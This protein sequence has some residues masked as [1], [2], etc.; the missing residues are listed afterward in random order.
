MFRENGYIV[1]N[2]DENKC[3]LIDPGS[4]LKPFEEKL[5][6]LNI[7][8]NSILLTHAHLDHISTA[9]CLQKKY[10]LSV[11][12]HRNDLELA[13]EL[14]EY[15][16]WFGMPKETP[17]KITNIIDDENEIIINGWSIKI[18]RTPGH[19]QGGVCFLFDKFVFVGDTLFSGSIGRTDLPGGNM[20]QLL[21]GINKSLLSLPDETIVYSGHGPE[22]TIGNEKQ[23]N[24]FIQQ[25]CS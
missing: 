15:C 17:P 16:K 22:T 1:Y 21:D 2:C 23:N 13:R 19:T 11:Y 25:N 6:L 24:V 3:I 14:P 8:P 5:N 7:V 12:L 20:K 10:D 4:E 18:L 9:H